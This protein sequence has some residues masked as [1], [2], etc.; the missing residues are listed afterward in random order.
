MGFGHAPRQSGN[1]IV[2]LDN[3]FSAVKRN[4]FLFRI[5]NRVL[6]SYP[7]YDTESVIMNKNIFLLKM[8]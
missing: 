5:P 1:T 8:R 4:I 6:Y 3:D 2:F 7:G